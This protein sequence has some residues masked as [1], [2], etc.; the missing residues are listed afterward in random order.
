MEWMI[1][2]DAYGGFCSVYKGTGAYFAYQSCCRLDVVTVEEC[3]CV[4]VCL[5]GMSRVRMSICWTAMW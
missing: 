5:C 1:G 4:C 3:M 2:Y